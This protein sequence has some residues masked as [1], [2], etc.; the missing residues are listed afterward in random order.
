MG[1]STLP[2]FWCFR[3]SLA[4]DKCWSLFQI[5]FARQYCSDFGLIL[6]TRPVLFCT[7]SCLSPD[8]TML[9]WPLTTAR[10]VWASAFTCTWSWFSMMGLQLLI[11]WFSSHSQYDVCTTWSCFALQPWQHLSDCFL[12]PADTLT[13]IL[14]CEWSCPSLQCWSNI[15]ITSSFHSF[16]YVTFI[17]LRNI[18]LIYF[19]PHSIW[20]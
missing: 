16:C 12:T 7:W 1:V 6:V 5:S 9:I 11:S 13:L 18:M 2:Y 15:N 17:P 19:S 14:G 20:S 4:N 8:S 3:L 10:P